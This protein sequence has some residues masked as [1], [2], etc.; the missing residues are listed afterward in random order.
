MVRT[1]LVLASLSFALAACGSDGRKDPC[2]GADCSAGTCHAGDSRE[3]YPADGS[4]KDVG[5]CTS[6]TQSCTAAGQWGDCQGAVIPVA[7]NCTD[8]VDN[9]CNGTAD[10]TDDLDGDGFKTC[11]PGGGPSDCCDSTECSNPGLVNPGAFDAPGNNLD[12]DCDGMIDNTLLLCDQGLVSNSAMAMDYAKAIDICQTATM[13][14][15]KWG[16]VDAQ[17]TLADGTGVPDPQEYAIRAHFG[18]GVLPQ[19]GV[20]MALISSGVAAG[21]GDMNPAYHDFVSYS[22]TMTSPFPADFAAAH[23]GNLPNAPGCPD[24]AGAVA[25][26]PVMLTLT[27][28]VPSNAKSFSL[29]SNFFS[30]EFPEWT[31]TQYNDFFVVLLD[32]TYAGS[33]ANPMD[34]NLAFYTQPGTMNTYPVGVNLAYGNTGLFTQCVN[35]ATGCLGTPGTISTCTGVTELTQTGFDDPAS[36]ECDTNSLKGGGTG[37]LTTSGNVAP[38]ELMKLRIAIWDTSDHL[39]DSLAVIDGFQWSVDTSQP[40]TV[41][42]R[43]DQPNN[44]AAVESTKPV[45]TSQATY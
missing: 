38:G 6:G 40:G 4:T 17:L 41:I 18:T 34:K 11:D 45:N 37:W 27:V 22:G 28:R 5:P 20:N 39:Y 7:E 12:D 9:N 21:K 24:P 13:A 2:V 15:K 44:P 16:V 26:D 29:K 33:P 35:G 19:G 14:D 32:S 30:A 1:Y 36:G 23:G 10:E 31:C 3:C 43:T 25:N 8:G 42:L